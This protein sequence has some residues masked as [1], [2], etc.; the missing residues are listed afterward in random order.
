MDRSRRLAK[1]WRLKDKINTCISA[2]VKTLSV[3]S[4]LSCK[5]CFCLHLLV[6]IFL[7][8]AHNAARTASES[9]VMNETRAHVVITDMWW[10][11]PPHASSVVNV[12]SRA[13]QAR[14][15]AVAL[16]QRCSFVNGATRSLVCGVLWLSSLYKKGEDQ[17][18]CASLLRAHRSRDD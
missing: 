15:R 8:A 1:R 4:V 18:G 2:V 6:S 13:G 9:L 10:S 3:F 7:C 12:L 14:F 17:A 5:T 16:S 11:D